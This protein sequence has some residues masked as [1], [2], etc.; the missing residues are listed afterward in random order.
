MNIALELIKEQKF[1]PEELCL[2]LPNQKLN[3]VFDVD[4]TLIYS[5]SVN[6]F[7]QLGLIKQNDKMWDQ[8]VHYIQ[9][10]KFFSNNKLISLI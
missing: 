1:T 9:I 6:E 7:P 10:C 8:R 3:I 5:I 2:R 4:H